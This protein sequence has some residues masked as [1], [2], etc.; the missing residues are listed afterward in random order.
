MSVL[1]KV[2]PMHENDGSTKARPSDM[3]LLSVGFDISKIPQPMGVLSL[4]A[5]QNTLSDT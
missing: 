1:R 5:V 4:D 3:C 2:D